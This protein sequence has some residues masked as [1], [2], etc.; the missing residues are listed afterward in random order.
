MAP[1]RHTRRLVGIGLVAV[2]LVA[3]AACS[4]SSADSTLVADVPRAEA[5]TTT[6]A[7]TTTR[8]RPTTTTAPTTTVA[9]TTTTA[10]ATTVAE[11]TTTA[12]ALPLGIQATRPIDPPLDAYARE[13]VVEMGRIIIPRLGV[14]TVMYSG[15]RM[16][17]L[18]RGPGHWPGSALAGEVGNVVVA[19]HRTSANRVFRYIEQLEPGDE[20]IFEDARGRF[21]YRA[22]RTEI[23]DPYTGLW[24]I[25]PTDTPT[26]TLF[27]CHPPGSVR[28]RIVVFGELV[29]A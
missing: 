3:V 28:Q 5:P 16:P 23:V 19:G 24:I 4:G 17:T 21:V 14:D 10:T 7:P 9:E 20:I 25:E 6:A 29:T 18:D 8:P 26:V 27:A 1:P 12:P 11:T 2:A 22:T 15:I 13:P